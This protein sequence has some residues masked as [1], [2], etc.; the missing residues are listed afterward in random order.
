MDIVYIGSACSV[1]KVLVIVCPNLVPEEGERKKKK[2]D[3][4]LEKV[5]LDGIDRRRISSALAVTKLSK[6]FISIHE[7]GHFCTLISGVLIVF[8]F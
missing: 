8:L 7:L 4:S 5:I 3:S 6:K 2:L 1:K